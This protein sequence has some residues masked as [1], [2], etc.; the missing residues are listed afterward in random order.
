MTSFVSLN[1]VDDDDTLA[2]P[3]VVCDRKDLAEIRL[4]AHEMLW[5]VRA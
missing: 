4:F 1:F 3:E 5:L 2:P